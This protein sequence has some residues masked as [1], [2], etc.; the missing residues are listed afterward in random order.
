MGKMQGWNFLLEQY[1]RLPPA[2][3]AS[4]SLAGRTVMII[5]ANTG[6]GLEAAKHFATMNPARLVLGC[7][8]EDKGRKAV[9]LITKETSCQ[10][11][12]LG[13][14]DLANFESVRAFAQNY[15]NDPLD[16]LLMNAALAVPTYETT[17]DGWELTLQVNHLSTALLALLLVPALARTAK[18]NSTHSRLVIVAS[19]THSWTQFGEDLKPENAPSMLEKLNERAYCTQKVMGTRYPDSKLLNVLFTRALAGH[20]SPTLPIIATAVN[21]GFCYS[22]LMRHVPGPRLIFI[23]IMQLFVARTA[24]QGARQLLW[25]ALGPDGKDGEHVKFLKGAYVSTLEVREPSDYVISKDGYEAQER[26]W[27]QLRSGMSHDVAEENSHKMY[28]G[29]GQGA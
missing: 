20:L 17:G 26:I 18:S 11:V 15:E 4:P 22:E 3:K 10:T 27:P 7:R 12:E 14:I 23:K 25:A 28:Q 13:L 1:T 9:E 19:N 5:G 8:N 16:I 21:P 24:E 6:I 29:G 2:L